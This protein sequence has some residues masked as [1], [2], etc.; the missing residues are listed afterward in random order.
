MHDP[1]TDLLN[2]RAIV[3]HINGAVARVERNE[4]TMAVCYLDLDNFKSINDRAGHAAGD[5]VLVETAR[6]LNQAVRAGDVVARIG[7]D[8]FIVVLEP[9]LNQADALKIA[10]RILD[11]TAEPIMFDGQELVAPP[12]IGLTISQKN[13]TAATLFARADK[14]LY[15][16]KAAGQGEPLLG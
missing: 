8:E 9:V 1:L 4:T 14:A 11:S 15:Q 6:R 5:A 7:G 10:R 3:E 13:D 2:R 16:A 12:S